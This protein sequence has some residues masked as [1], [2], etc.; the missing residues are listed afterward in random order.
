M[1]TSTGWSHHPLPSKQHSEKSH[2]QRPDRSVNLISNWSHTRD[3]CGYGTNRCSYCSHSI[4]MLSHDKLT[5]LHDISIY[6]T[7]CDTL[8]VINKALSQTKSPRPNFLREMA[9]NL[10]MPIFFFGLGRY[11]MWLFSQ[12]GS[13]SNSSCVNVFF[14]NRE[15][16]PN[17][18]SL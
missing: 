14:S 2:S 13:K 18:I 6:L 5:C 10:K 9:R 4:Q 15:F 11:G 1:Y 7:A 8:K 17:V 12:E 3:F 16:A